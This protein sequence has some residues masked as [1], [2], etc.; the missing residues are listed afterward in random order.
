MDNEELA[1]LG[2]PGP[3]R[4]A[5]SPGH[6]PPTPARAAMAAT[7]S[8]GG[9][10]LHNARTGRSPKSL[11]FSDRVLTQP[12]SDSPDRVPGDEADEAD[13]AEVN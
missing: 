3:T 5:M 11:S 9:S 2:A 6:G 1:L 10:R 8:P 7:S 13:E 4:P 12:S